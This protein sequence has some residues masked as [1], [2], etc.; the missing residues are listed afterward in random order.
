[1]ALIKVS[2]TQSFAI[3]KIIPVKFKTDLKAFL[4]R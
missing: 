3:Q 2:E 4:K 1:M